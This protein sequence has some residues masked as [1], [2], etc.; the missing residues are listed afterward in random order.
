[1]CGIF[2]IVS[3]NTISSAELRLLA[4]HAQQRGKDSSGLFISKTNGYNLHRA[5]IAITSLLRMSTP[6]ER[7]S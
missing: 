1:M 5:N 4:R 3:S 6:Q 7:A 2:G